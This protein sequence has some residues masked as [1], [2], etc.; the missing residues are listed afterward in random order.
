MKM[1]V[2]SRAESEVIPHLTISAPNGGVILF[3]SEFS[4]LG[5][6]QGAEAILRNDV[7]YG[8]E[9]DTP[10]LSARL[11]AMVRKFAISEERFFQTSVDIGAT[12][13]DCQFFRVQPFN[14]VVSHAVFA[15]HLKRIPSMDHSLERVVEDYRLTD[16]E[17]EILKGISLGLTSKALAK[18]LNISPNTVNSFLRMIMIKLGVTTRA[19]IVGIALKER[20]GEGPGLRIARRRGMGF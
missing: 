20:S 19:G 6:D 3:D 12:E 1:N 2:M 15:L 8:A 16:R 11:R 4:T 9:L 17:S 13:Y 10:T 18:R 7:D 5:L 14:G